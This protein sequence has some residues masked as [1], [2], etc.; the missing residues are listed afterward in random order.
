M[1]CAPTKKNWL[2]R[3]VLLHMHPEARTKR[4]RKKKNRIEI[5]RNVLVIISV[6]AHGWTCAPTAHRRAKEKKIVE[7]H[8]IALGS[9][10]AILRATAKTS[11]NFFRERFGRV[12]RTSH[13]HTQ[14]QPCFVIVRFSEVFNFEIVSSGIYIYIQ[15][16][17]AYGCVRVYGARWHPGTRS[18]RNSR[19]ENFQE[20]QIPLETWMQW[21]GISGDG[22][23]SI[24]LSVSAMKAIARASAHQ[25]LNT[26]RENNFLKSSFTAHTGRKRQKRKKEKRKRMSDN[27]ETNNFYFK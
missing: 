14:I 19:K 7:P 9:W 5:T 17:G 21:S 4:E 24:Q 10:C 18:R 27:D 2:F 22:C 20:L 15:G 13:I 16:A 8:F 1:M 3:R 11:C 6:N 25:K 12:Q 23:S 26:K